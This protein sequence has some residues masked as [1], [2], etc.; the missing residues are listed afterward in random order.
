MIKALAEY[1]DFEIFAVKEK[2]VK[3]SGVTVLPADQSI[4]TSEMEAI[5]SGKNLDA[6]ELRQKAWQRTK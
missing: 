4:D 5:F 1:L 2:K 6:K 3:I